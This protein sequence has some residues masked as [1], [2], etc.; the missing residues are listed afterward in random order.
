MW[1]IWL[2]LDNGLIIHVPEGTK[3]RN[4]PLLV[5]GSPKIGFVATDET[6][7]NRGAVLDG[8]LYSVCL[9]VSSVQEI[10][11]TRDSSFVIRHSGRK[12]TRSPVRNGGEP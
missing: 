5:N 2:L 11:V 9:E 12:D 10:L 8:N 1:R 6:E 7:N 4:S 3:S